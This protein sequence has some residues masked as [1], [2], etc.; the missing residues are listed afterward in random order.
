M[1]PEAA[2]PHS[3][4][5]RT[6]R[7][8]ARIAP[9]WRAPLV[10]LALFTVLFVALFARDWLAMADQWW[11]SSTYTHI[12]LIPPIVA[13]LVW[14]RIPEL[15]RLAPRGW[16]PGLALFA[17]AALV[18]LLG[19]LAGLNLVSEAGTVTMLIAA[20]IAILGPRVAA[21]LAFPLAYLLLIV[22]FG[23]EFVPQLQTITARLTIALI[24]LSGVRATISGVFIDTPAGLFEVA[25]ACS[26]VKFLV[27]MG[28]LGLLIAN[29]CFA[30]WTRRALLMAAALTVPILANGIR[31]WGTI[32]V[33]QF[34]GAAYAGS[35]DHIVYGWI[36]FALVIALVIA[37]A[38]P[39]FDR[40]VDAPM[41][42]VVALEASPLLAR[43]S[44]MTMPALVVAALLLGLAAG[45]RLWGDRAER[46]V[47]PVP[48]QIALPEVPGWHRVDYTPRLPWAPRAQ[49]ADHRLL[50]RYGDEAGHRVDV[51]YA[52]YS[53]QGPGRE[54]DGFGQG[55]LA[56]HSG[57][58]WAAMSAAG[59]QASGEI[60]RASGNVT[61]RAETSYRIGSLT[62]GR[63]A[64][65]RLAVMAD[66]L[67]LAAQ[68]VGVLILSSEGDPAAPHVADIAAFRRAIGPLGAW[69][70][71]AAATR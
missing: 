30:S 62:T 37:L 23:D 33:A 12:L 69:M 17:G 71:R 45:V 5:V 58:A 54:A 57:W 56:P 1:P 51:F 16:W 36:F 25:E 32:Y 63:G 4:A 49:G 47:A 46:L 2:L 53:R 11:N 34:K 55:A 60:L 67:D 64:R 20:I 3:R 68:P 10:H 48:A 9:P 13:W 61:R 28:A 24:H 70:D 15:A 65:L 27:A 29:L 7:W 35:F 21:A 40:A 31:A 44:A 41:V 14:L 22:P 26:G 8:A 38:W 19:T 52:L 39:F 50:G 43:L 6:H 66:R 59:P 42:D 18:W